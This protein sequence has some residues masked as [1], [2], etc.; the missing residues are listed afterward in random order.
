MGAAGTE[1]KEESDMAREELLAAAAALQA[2]ILARPQ[3]RPALVTAMRAKLAE[4]RAAGMA[5]P[6]EFAQFE[7][8]ISGDPEEDIFDNLPV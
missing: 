3:D 5:V 4:M 6:A 2:E 7:D 1:G 8:Q